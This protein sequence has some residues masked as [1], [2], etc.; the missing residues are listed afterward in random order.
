MVPKSSVFNNICD[1]SVIY[2]PTE[3][4]L[5]TSLD[6]ISHALSHHLPS[7]TP[8]KV[9]G[10]AP[11][12][13]SLVP[14]SPATALCSLARSDLPQDSQRL[15]HPV[16]L[17]DQPSLCTHTPGKLGKQGA[18]SCTPDL[19]PL[20]GSQPWSAWT[21]VSLCLLSTSFL[22]AALA[23]PHFSPNPQPTSPT[24]HHYALNCASC[25]I[26]MSKS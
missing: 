21:L 22:S 19:Q 5:L 8:A 3:T 17:T 9:S 20:Q 12:P 24:S 14:D 11:L 13:P 23:I 1:I 26:H 15:A 18:P 6:S 7:L 4:G 10:R 25:Q 2:S 16:I